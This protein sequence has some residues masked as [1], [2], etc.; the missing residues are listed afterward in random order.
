MSDRVELDRAWAALTRP[1][2]AQ[3]STYRVATIDAGSVRAGIDADGRRLILVPAEESASPPATP[4][5]MLVI[6]LERAQFADE[7]RSYLVI[8]CEDRLLWNEFSAL[9]EDILDAVVAADEPAGTALQVLSKWRRLLAATRGNRLGPGQR[10][11]LFSELILLR[12]A[13]LAEPMLGAQVWTGPL[14]ATHDFDIEGHHFEVKAVGESSRTVTV[15]GIDQLEPPETGRLTLAVAL[16]LESAEGSPIRAIVEDIV[17]LLEDPT[18][19]T[20]LLARAGWTREDAEVPYA[21]AEWLLVEVD[22]RT[23]RLVR[24]D[25][26]LG[27]L[28]EGVGRVSY[29]VDLDRIRPLAGSA[30]LT[31]AVEDALR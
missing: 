13:L 20:I 15:H 18:E 19:F 22:D 8:G 25:L 27:R 4:F 6:R 3:Y 11:A 12:A 26:A 2:I 7:L 10:I 14:R 5:P 31:A 1:E 9:G 28:R 24:A 16:V 23:P 30:T 21:I 17:S 29:D